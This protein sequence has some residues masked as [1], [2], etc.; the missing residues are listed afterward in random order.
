MLLSIKELK[1]MIMSSDFYY[2][3]LIRYMKTDAK[4][5]ECEGMLRIYVIWD[6]VQWQ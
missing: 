3:N 6:R 5:T 2:I 4:E 1:N